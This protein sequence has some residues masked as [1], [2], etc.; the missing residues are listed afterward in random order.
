MFH[1]YSILDKKQQVHKNDNHKSQSNLRSN[2]NAHAK[3]EIANLPPS[4]VVACNGV[5]TQTLCV[6][7]SICHWIAPTKSCVVGTSGFIE[8]S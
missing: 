1:C 8:Q 3:K 5:K 2:V 6:Q 4:E 7:N